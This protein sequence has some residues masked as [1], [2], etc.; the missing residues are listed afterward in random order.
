MHKAKITIQLNLFKKKEEEK[1]KKKNP[2]S[3]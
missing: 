2:H 1:K 3:E